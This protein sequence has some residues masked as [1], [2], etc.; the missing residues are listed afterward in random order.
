MGPEASG[1]PGGRKDVLNSCWDSCFQE[2]PVPPG[3]DKEAAFASSKQV[4]D[5]GIADSVYLGTSG[6]LVTFLGHSCLNW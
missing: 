1:F 5:P 3:Q 6:V 2:T 4:L